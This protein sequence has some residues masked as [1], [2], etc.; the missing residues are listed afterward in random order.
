MIVCSNIIKFTNKR[1]MEYFKH[2]KYSHFKPEFAVSKIKLTGFEKLIKFR[3]T[4]QLKDA[5]FKIVV[6]SSNIWTINE[7]KI[8]LEISGINRVLQKDSKKLR[9]EV[10]QT[11][12][13]LSTIGNVRN[14]MLTFILGKIRED[15]N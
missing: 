3:H 7:Q 1:M 2:W 14:L 5:F 4:Q 12:I 13:A 8:Q 10:T 6:N 11:E 15:D 9:A